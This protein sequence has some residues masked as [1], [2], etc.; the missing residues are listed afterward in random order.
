MKKIYFF[1]LT[2]MLLLPFLAKAEE[3]NMEDI[4]QQCQNAYQAVGSIIC[5]ADKKTADA[6]IAA[7]AKAI[8]TFNQIAFDAIRKNKNFLNYYNST[9]GP[10]DYFHDETKSEEFVNTLCGEIINQNQED[11]ENCLKD[12]GCSCPPDL[13]NDLD[14]RT[15]ELTICN[16]DRTKCNGDLTKRTNEFTKC[17]GDLTTRTGELATCNTDRTKCNNDL[18][19]RTSELTTCNTDRTKCNN[20]LT[21]RTSE[22]AT[23][24]T[25]RTKCNN[26]LTTRTSELTTCNTARTKCNGDLA[27]CN[28][29]LIAR[30]SELTKCNGDLT[31]RTSELATYNTDRTKCNGDLTTCKNEQAENIKILTDLAKLKKGI[32]SI[33]GSNKDLSFTELVQ[34]L[35]KLI[36]GDKNNANSIRKLSYSELLI[37]AAACKKIKL[38]DPENS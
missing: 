30:T 27:T 22:L 8:S 38:S 31:T 7:V 9:N 15:S 11:L 6:G 20:D 12:K 33:I 23:C 14:T 10:K 5:P 32:Q 2:F 36:D 34:E 17:N 26:D 19:T 3:T 13:K 4:T 16:T 25:D 21:T 37:K 28:T 18:T 1:K 24:N 29:N 35:S